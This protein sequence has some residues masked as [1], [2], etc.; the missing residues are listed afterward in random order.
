MTLISAYRPI[1]L[2][3]RGES[4]GDVRGKM[5]GY[6]VIYITLHNELALA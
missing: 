3:I 6:H 5:S 1:D 2:F 4:P